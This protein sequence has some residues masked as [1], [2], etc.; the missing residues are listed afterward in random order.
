M[1]NVLYNAG[2][3]WNTPETVALTEALTVLKENSKLHEYLEIHPD[4][5]LII[6]DINIEEFIT[7]EEYPT[8]EEYELIQKYEQMLKRPVPIISLKEKIVLG[9]KRD[10]YQYKVHITA[11]DTKN[12]I[13]NLTLIIGFTFSSLIK[14]IS[15]IEA[16]LLQK[17]KKSITLPHPEEGRKSPIIIYKEWWNEISHSNI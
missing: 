9:E 3:V 7:A 13:Y 16:H 11:E 8:E 14:S 17:F 12:F 10:Y 4:E 6:T 1:V 5:T 2:I 15:Y